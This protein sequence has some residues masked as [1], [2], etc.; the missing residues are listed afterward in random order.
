MRGMTSVRVAAA[1]A[2]VVG[3]A[4]CSDDDDPTGP[5][6]EL[7]AEEADLMMEAW[8]EL[9]GLGGPFL[10]MGGYEGAPTPD[11][12]L[13]ST[14][15]S[16]DFNQQNDCPQG[17]TITYNGTM[18]WAENHISWDLTNTADNCQSNDSEGNTWTFNGG[19]N[20]DFE[21]TGDQNQFQMNG[22]QQGSLSFSSDVGSG[23]CDV[24]VSYSAQGDE[25]SG[26]AEVS[27]SV[28]GHDVSHTE[29]W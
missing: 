3:V 11:G 1:L 23:S 22:S 12:V 21:F 26:T 15:G 10:A 20:T 2:L 13:Y 28:C 14:S 6:A 27:G 4:A 16:E 5:G 29:S 24:N 18:T 7:S 19:V 25:N 8:A 17:G 9:G